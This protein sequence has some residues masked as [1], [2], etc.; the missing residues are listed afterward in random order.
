MQTSH[1]WRGASV[2][3]RSIW[4][5]TDSVLVWSQ[6]L[7]GDLSAGLGVREVLIAE[8][9]KGAMSRLRSESGLA[10][11]DASRRLCQPPRRSID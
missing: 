6:S 4:L 8:A 10:R 5:E 2:L 9:T 3:Q 11:L 1:L 7:A